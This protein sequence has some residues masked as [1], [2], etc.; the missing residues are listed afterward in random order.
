MS[1]TA[2]SATRGRFGYQAFTRRSASPSRSCATAAG[3]VSGER[4]LDAATEGLRRPAPRQRR[5]RRRGDE[6]GGLSAAADPPRGPRKRQ[7]GLARGP[8]G[9]TPGRTAP[10]AATV[11]REG[12]RRRRSGRRAR[13]RHRSDAGDADPGPARSQGRSPPRRA[14]GRRRHSPHDARRRSQRT[15]RFQ[16]GGEEALLRALQKRSSPP[17]DAGRS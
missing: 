5:R 6:R 8:D 16:P 14:A 1:T 9:W 2:G 12:V 7:R 11:G 10:V 3:P 15:A 17:G 13:D 4:A